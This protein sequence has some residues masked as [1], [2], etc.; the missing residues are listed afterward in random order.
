MRG[1]KAR[2]IPSQRITLG[3]IRVSTDKQADKGLSLDDQRARI[4]A[5]AV[6]MGW[7]VSEVIVDAGAS[8]KTLKR[9]GITKLL[10]AIR[11]DEVQRVVIVKLDR[12]TRSTRDLDEV[13][14]LCQKH[15]VSLVSLTESLDT[16][17]A[18]GLFFVGML[19]QISQWERGIISERTRDALEF[20]RRSG[21]VYSRCTPFGYRRDGD[22]LVRDD[23]QHEALTVAKAMHE[24]GASLRQIA[25]RLEALGVKPN[26]GTRWYAQSVKH[27]L[28]SRMTEAFA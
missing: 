21:K 23:A 10:D 8:A 14:D 24:D 16:K 27:V 11:R 26:N 4:A 22:R 19:A 9:P 5:Y 3:Y 7:D 12:L 6:A 2:V 18:T 15:D 17:S 28:T 1:R 13:L 25:A 20:R